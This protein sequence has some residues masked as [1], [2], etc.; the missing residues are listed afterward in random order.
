[1]PRRWERRAERWERRRARSRAEHLE[2][3]ARALRR[4]RVAEGS[5]G[6]GT[7]LTERVIVFEGKHRGVYTLYARNGVLLG[8]AGTVDRTPPHRERVDFHAAIPDADWDEFGFARAPVDPL[9]RAPTGRLLSLLI[10]DRFGDRD[11]VVLNA[12][13]DELVRLQ[14]PW[15]SPGPGEP[16]QPRLTGSKHQRRSAPSR[17]IRWVQC[18]GLAPRRV[19]AGDGRFL[20]WVTNAQRRLSNSQRLVFDASGRTAAIVT[21]TV[22]GTTNEARSYVVDVHEPVDA[23]L[24]ATALVVGPLWDWYTIAWEAG[25]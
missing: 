16:S 25:G 19:M 3:I 15:R 10:A 8:T 22:G 12:E 9:P 18:L 2:R 11:D 13:G 6:G 17:P 4:A 5:V 24:H 1:M 7:P 14:N 23:R 21:R 20:G